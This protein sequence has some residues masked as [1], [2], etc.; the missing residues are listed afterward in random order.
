MPNRRHW[1][2]QI[3]PG[4]LLAATGV[5]AGDILTTSLAGSEV[6][7]VLMWTVVAGAIL[8]FTLSEG[9]ARWQLA[10]G[11]TVLEG[12]ALRLGSW[13]RWLFFAYLLLFTL[14]V[15][16]ALISACG[17]A[18]TGFLTIGDPRTSRVFWGILHSAAGLLLAW[19]GSFRLFEI[20]MAVLAGTMFFAV[21]LTAV[22][23]GPDYRAVAAGFVPS[24]PAQDSS[25]VLAVLGGV[26][27]T[28]T[29][30]SYGYW[31][32]EEGRSGLADV[33]VC[34]LDLA[35]GN[36][37]TAI[38]GLGALII[39]SRLDLEGQGAVLATQLADQLAG[40]VGPWGKWLFLAGF[41]GAVFSSLLGVWQSIPYLFADF[42]ELSRIKNPDARSPNLRATR[43][44]RAWLL[45]ISIIPLGAL[46]RPVREIQLAYG[47]IACL[48]M[49]LLAL[50]LLILNNRKACIGREFATPRLANIVLLVG[51]AL[52]SY[53]GV[54]ELIGLLRG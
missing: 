38:F 14:S 11:S 9:I 22:A 24:I 36:G 47:I 17:V 48:F 54:Q 15:G 12:W 4:I 19:R 23:I 42:F 51:L 25:W 39:G 13:I 45:F 30:L 20:V 46:F 18:G 6:G 34:R 29:L 41:W 1:F 16:S 37:M 7:L 21:V 28:V 10:T 26:G 53:L 27:G 32:R 5:G 33:R 35:L 44:Y 49:P 2:S 8:K 31:I 43:P 40:V 50:T 3:A 52:F